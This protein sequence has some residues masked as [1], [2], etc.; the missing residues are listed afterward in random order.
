MLDILI[1]RIKNNLTDD[2]RKPKYRGHHNKLWG[3]CY[4]ASE[5]LYH[6]WGKK[7]GYK[8]RYI[9][10]DGD[11]H[12]FLENEDA[13]IDVTESQFKIKPDYS[14]SKGSG[15]LT[16]EPSKRSVELMKR[17]IHE[18]EQELLDGTKNLSSFRA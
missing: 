9:K 4:V 7:Y 6:L 16:K 14:K 3:H 11:T 17:I 12:W 15:F 8:P 13:I 1:K 10:I 2:L 5:T 18:Q